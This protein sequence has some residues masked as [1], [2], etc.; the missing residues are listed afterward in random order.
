MPL[1][2]DRYVAALDDFLSGEFADLDRERKHVDDVIERTVKALEHL[3][4]RKK[5]WPYEIS[6]A[7][8]RDDYEWPEHPSPSTIAMISAA[9][10]AAAGCGQISVLSQHVEWQPEK[11]RRLPSDEKRILEIVQEGWKLIVTQADAAM[12]NKDPW[13]FRSGTFGTDDVFTLCWL[14]DLYE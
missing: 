11:A 10:A 7:R 13:T 4:D 8:E 3:F 14:V 6:L 2:K 5:G 9:L 12:A 1:M